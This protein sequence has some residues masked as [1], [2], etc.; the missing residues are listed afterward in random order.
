MPCALAFFLS[1]QLLHS[2][3]AAGP[4]GGII[5]ARACAAAENRRRRRAVLHRR[6]PAAPSLLPQILNG[7]IRVVSTINI[8]IV[9]L[10]RRGLNSK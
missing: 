7:S 2:S 8:I 3:A 1:L 9:F 4:S 10:I 5:L 6:R